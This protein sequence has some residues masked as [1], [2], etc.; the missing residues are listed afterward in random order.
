MRV[1]SP[2]T[3]K[4][5]IIKTD[6]SLL[7]AE[8]H[9]MEIAYHGRQA[10]LVSMLD[11]SE[12]KQAQGALQ[13]RENMLSSIFRAAPT[14]IGVVRDRVLTLVNSRICE[15]TGWTQEELIGKSSRLLYPSD[16]D[17]EYV[18]KEKYRQIAEQGTGTVETRWQ[19]K[20]GRIID[21]LLS[22]TPINP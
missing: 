2:E 12:R 19:C 10:R 9:G 4:V 3:Y 8:T 18:G 11:I 1:A 5:D 7:S 13:A 16:A 21:V 20:D 6:G 15:M 17:F 14:G 22:S